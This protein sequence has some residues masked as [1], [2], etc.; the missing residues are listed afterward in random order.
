MKALKAAPFLALTAVVALL[1][2]MQFDG[3]ELIDPPADTALAQ[4]LTALEAQAAAPLV[5][6]RVIDLPE[7]GSLWQTIVIYSTPD[8][9]APADRRLASELATTPRLVS[10]QAQT[11]VYELDP[12]HW[13]VAQHAAGYPLP[14]VIVQQP[15]GDNRATVAYKADATALPESGEAMA[16]QIARGI[17]DCRPRPNPTPTPAPVN[18]Q[19]IPNTIPNIG[20][21]EGDEGTNEIGWLAYAI[22][23]AA[24]LGGAYYGVKH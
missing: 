6:E 15:S 4:R 8:K 17:A 7:D 21:P 13:W 22:I 20:P 24:G 16:D 10:L 18:P 12:R 11:K 2:F 14:C 3:K 5:S 1:A 9:S 23:A 19:P